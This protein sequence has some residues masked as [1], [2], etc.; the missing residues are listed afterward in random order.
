MCHT[1][2]DSHTKP[3]FEKFN[4]VQVTNYYD[5]KLALSYKKVVFR[6]HLFL[7]ISHLEFEENTYNSRCTYIW[8][9][10]HSRAII[11][12]IK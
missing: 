2:D 12:A 11:L 5:Y 3:L 4:I 7:S 9:V 10:P 1:S 6:N 8:T